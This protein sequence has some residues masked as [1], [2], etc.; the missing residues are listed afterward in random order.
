MTYRTGNCHED[1]F[2]KLTGFDTKYEWTLVHGM[3][4]GTS[5][6]AGKIGRYPHS[7]LE[8]EH[9]AGH[10]LVWDPNTGGEYPA[11]FYYYAGKIVHEDC[12]PFTEFF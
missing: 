12:N 7:W 1:A 4:I 8:R 6:A 9:V 3:P 10:T 2:N 11:G 5:G